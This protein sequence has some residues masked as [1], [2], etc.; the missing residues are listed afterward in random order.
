MNNKSGQTVTSQGISLDFSNAVKYHYNQFPPDKL[1]YSTL[2]NPLG[3][4]SEAIGR[5]DQML[6]N[7][8]NSEIL[9]APLRRQEAVISSR[10]EGTVSTMDEILS[11]E[12]DKN[13]DEEDGNLTKYRPDVGETWLYANAL[14]QAQDY[15]SEGRPINRFL[16]RAIHK[17]LLLWGRGAEKSPGKFKEEQ[18]YIVDKNKKN[19][20]FIPITPELL[21]SGLDAMF[22]YLN[23]DDE[24]VLIKTAISH[25][26]FESLHPFQ[27][28]N[29][30]IGRMLITLYLWKSGVISA[31]HFYV[32]GFLEEEKARYLDSMREVSKNGNWTEWC[33]FFLETLEQQATRNLKI[34]EDIQGLYK[35]MSSEFRDLLTTKWH[36]TALD[37]LFT[38][39]IFRNSKFTSGSGIPYATANR[40]TKVLLEK[41]YLIPLEEAA[42]RRAGLYSFEP[43]MKLVR[44]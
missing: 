20:L 28:G 34:A 16:I 23:N 10:M 42:G 12:A 21:E 32:S 17:Q 26:E 37:F 18:N 33:V 25:V 2:I 8:H 4:A 44:V 40:F 6:K 19:V 15:I 11:Y 14:K 31:P 9:L 1:N 41:G 3:R 36:H 27:D 35:T 22:D 39:P 5:F 29:G 7:M 13:E 30:R 43:L 38:Q 24:Q